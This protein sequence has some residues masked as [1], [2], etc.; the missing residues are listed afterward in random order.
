[1]CPFYSE[2]ESTC[3]SAVKVPYKLRSYLSD[4]VMGHGTMS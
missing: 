3:G 2:K 1:M 4:K